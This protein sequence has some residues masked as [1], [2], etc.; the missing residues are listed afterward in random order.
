VC[1]RERERESVCVCVRQR[2][3]EREREREKNFCT[4]LFFH[5]RVSSARKVVVAFLVPKSKTKYVLD[6]CVGE[7]GGGG[8]TAPTQNHFLDV[9]GIAGTCIAPSWNC[10]LYIALIHMHN[11]PNTWAW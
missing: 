1:E 8:L 6:V 3:K 7:G 10:L 9:R 4:I 2:E 5:L 11:Q